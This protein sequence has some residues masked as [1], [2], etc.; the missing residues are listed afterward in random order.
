MRGAKQKLGGVV[1]YQQSGRTLARELAPQVSNPRTS[2]QMNQRTKLAN[3]VEMYKA[4]KFWMK[5]AFENKPAKESDYNAFVKA[6]L[7]TSLVTQSKSEAAANACVVAPYVVTSGSILSIEHEVNG[8]MLI[9][10][11]FLGDLVINNNTTVGDFSTAVIANNNQIREGMQL[12]LIVNMQRVNEITGIPYVV[13]RAFELIFNKT[14]RALLSDFF[15]SG[16]LGNDGDQSDQLRANLRTLEYGGACFIL[17][18]TQSGRTAVSSQSLVM[19][20]PNAV[21]EQYTAAGKAATDAESYGENAEA[22]LDSYSANTAAGVAISAQ[23]TKISISE[24]DITP[25]STYPGS[26]PD[27]DPFQVSFSSALSDVEDTSAQLIVIGTGVTY[28]L[29]ASFDELEPTLV[30]V[31]ASQEIEFNS[32][33]PVR[34]AVNVDGKIYIMDFTMTNGDID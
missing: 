17:S 14:S 21:Y 30:Y 9:S 24:V 3:V 2:S 7:A 6:N 1:F 29:E 34:L 5:G 32:P 13:V 10:N 18:E 25:G 12:S 26:I 33:T 23:I 4:N 16:I 15:G 8:L 22:F 28:E 27:A 11:I 31:T 19:Y 20:G